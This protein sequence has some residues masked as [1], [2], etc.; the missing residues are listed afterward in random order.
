M[1]GKTNKTAVQLLGKMYHIKGDIDPARVNVITQALDKRM[2]EIAR[3]NYRLAPEMVA[4]LAA[5][6]TMD[7]YLRLKE[8]YEQLMA[9]IKEDR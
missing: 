9:M 1:D 3:A 5:L 7:E 6:N 2:K 4:V 8:D